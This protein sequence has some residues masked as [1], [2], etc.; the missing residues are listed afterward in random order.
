[1]FHGY[2]ITQEE[3]IKQLQELLLI[4]I[5]GHEKIITFDPDFSINAL[6]INALDDKEFKKVLIDKFHNFSWPCNDTYMNI[7]YAN[8]F[9]ETSIV[10]DDCKSAGEKLLT[11]LTLL[12][13][14]YYL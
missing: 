4:Y 14:E 7:E 5:K 8:G 1:M 12:F 3:A 9:F 2:A 10:I 6:K 11:P 13:P